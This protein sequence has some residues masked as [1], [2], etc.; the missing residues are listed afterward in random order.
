MRLSISWG[1]DRIHI[2]FN[3]YIDIQSS[4]HNSLFYYYILWVFEILWSV[5]YFCTIRFG[6]QHQL[7]MIVLRESHAQVLNRGVYW[8]NH[9]Y[10][11]FTKSKKTNKQKKT[12]INPKTA[13]LIWWTE[14]KFLQNQFLS[15]WMIPK[16]RLSCHNLSSWREKVAFSA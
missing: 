2:L 10:G 12:L 6:Y 15:T 16:S 3:R 11:Y 9:Y 5:M 13:V 4:D 7:V 1:C 8:W 14:Q